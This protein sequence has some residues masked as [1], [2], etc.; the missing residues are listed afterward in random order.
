VSDDLRDAMG[1]LRSTVHSA[2]DP[3][4]P[5]VLRRDVLDGLDET[6]ALL[7]AVDRSSPTVLLAKELTA[8]A[9]VLRQAAFVA[10]TLVRIEALQTALPVIPPLVQGV[11]AGER[12]AALRRA[13]RLTHGELGAA[14]GV[15]EASV[16]SFEQDGKNRIRWFVRRLAV[17]LAAVEPGVIDADRVEIEL[18]ELI[19]ADLRSDG[20]WD[21]QRVEKAEKAATP[22]DLVRSRRFRRLSMETLL[23]GHG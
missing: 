10:E 7:S 1:Q 15:R 3:L 13:A 2:Q 11:S 16:K 6:V 21:W 8:A 22:A 23:G 17:G 5:P 12:L 14:A 18:I 4:S 20:A 19:G 9:S